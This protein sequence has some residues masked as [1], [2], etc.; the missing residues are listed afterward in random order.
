MTFIQFYVVRCDRII[1]FNI[2]QFPLKIVVLNF[3]NKD[4]LD[5]ATFDKLSSM[6]MP[7]IIPIV[8]WSIVNDKC[9]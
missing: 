7:Y 9:L 8:D 1:R 4:V 3:W 2:T 6:M 5:F